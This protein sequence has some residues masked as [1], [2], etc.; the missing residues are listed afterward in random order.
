MRGFPQDRD[1]LLSASDRPV[2]RRGPATFDTSAQWNEWATDLIEKALVQFDNEVTIPSQNELIA[3]V[4][5]EFS[6]VFK[7]LM[8]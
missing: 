1:C 6:E 7:Q 5:K 4:T 8:N 3:D 2:I